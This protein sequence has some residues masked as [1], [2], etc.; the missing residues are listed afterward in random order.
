MKTNIMKYEIENNQKVYSVEEMQR[1]IQK[2][3]SKFVEHFYNIKL[4][5]WQRIY[6]DNISKIQRSNMLHFAHY[7]FRALKEL[8]EYLEKNN[9][10]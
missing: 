7:I 2:H 5:R 6:V 3:P 9:T 8:K 1:F 10:N 4:T